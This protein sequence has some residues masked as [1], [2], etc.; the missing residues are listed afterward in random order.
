MKNIITLNYNEEVYPI[1]EVTDNGKD[2]IMI[3]FLHTHAHYT[4][5]YPKIVSKNDRSVTF[6]YAG[7]NIS[8]PRQDEHIVFTEHDPASAWSTWK[9]EIIEIA[10]KLKLID[11]ERHGDYIQHKPLIRGLNPAGYSLGGRRLNL[12][13]HSHDA[14]YLRQSV[15]SIG[16]SES[17]N[18]MMWTVLSTPTNKYSGDMIGSFKTTMGDLCFY[19][20]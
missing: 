4:L 17:K 10:R 3:R 15:A 14:K 16:L 11:P 8:V 18:P 2:Q 12:Q 1:L 9:Y 7:E 20:E 6:K 19:F 5:H 13:K